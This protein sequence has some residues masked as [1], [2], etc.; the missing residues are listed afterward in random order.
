MDRQCFNCGV[1]I[2]ACMGFVKAGDFLE[3]SNDI[4]EL[5]GKCIFLYEMG[6]IHFELK[7][8]KLKYES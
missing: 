5:C 1:E 2:N 6:T 4:R 7:E 8:E 3:N